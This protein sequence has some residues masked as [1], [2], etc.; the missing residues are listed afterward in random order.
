HLQLLPFTLPV[1]S[2]PGSTFGNRNMAGEAV[3]LAL[4][5]GFALLAADW[6]PLRGAAGSVGDRERALRPWFDVGLLMV[7]LVYLAVTRA[8]GAWI[9]GAAGIVAFMV[10]RRPALSRAALL[11]PAGAVVMV[12]ALIPGRWQ[13]RD[14]ND[15]KRYEPGARLV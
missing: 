4:P 12:A 15:T 1:I 8:R 3:A 11:L 6:R 5:F 9:G 2:V 7:Q 13:P 14:A 10:V